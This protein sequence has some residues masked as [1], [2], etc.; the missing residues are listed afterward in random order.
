M[1]PANNSTLLYK[2]LFENEYNI[3]KI[4]TLDKIPYRKSDLLINFYRNKDIYFTKIAEIEEC[5]KIGNQVKTANN[6][7]ITDYNIE[8]KIYEIQRYSYPKWVFEYSIICNLK[9]TLI[10]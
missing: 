2:F 5:K 8:T 4:Y 7:S 9:N 6:L 3:T 10:T 1:I